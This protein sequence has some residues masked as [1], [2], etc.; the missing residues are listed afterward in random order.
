MRQVNFSVDDKVYDALSLRA[1]K[2]GYRAT[3]YAKMLF[4]AAFACRVGVS[5]DPDLQQRIELVLILHAAR[6]DT[7]RISTFSGLSEATVVR[8]IDSWRSETA[9]DAAE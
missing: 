5:Q 8:I 3:S 1:E 9:Q 2:L 4:E 7:A 6:Q